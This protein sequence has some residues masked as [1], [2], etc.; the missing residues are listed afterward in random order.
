MT[1]QV[2]LRPSDPPEDLAAQAPIPRCGVP[3]ANAGSAN[4][5]A[6]AEWWADGRVPTDLIP[7]GSSLQATRLARAIASWLR[8]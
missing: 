6:V 3:V 2:L 8:L 7:S 5:G 4:A 1:L